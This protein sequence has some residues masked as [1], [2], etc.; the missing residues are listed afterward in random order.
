MA[1]IPASLKTIL[2]CEGRVDS[3]LDRMPEKEPSE[4]SLRTAIAA[5]QTVDLVRLQLVAKT[6]DSRR[7]EDLLQEAIVRTLSGERTWRDGIPIFWHLFFAIKSIA[8]DWRS[9]CDEKLILESQV[10]RDANGA[11]RSFSDVPAYSPDPERLAAARVAFEKLKAKFA[12]DE[13]ALAILDGKLEGKTEDEIVKGA[14]LSHRDFA[15]A[16]QRLR[17][18]ARTNAKGSSHAGV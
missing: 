17:R 10:S 12:K 18:S 5:I 3:I 16:V 6:F 2:L 7:H 4:D 1:A 15:A 13:A 11:S 8:W 9:K 14:S